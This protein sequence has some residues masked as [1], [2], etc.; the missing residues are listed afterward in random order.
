MKGGGGTSWAIALSFFD[1]SPLRPLRSRMPTTN[2]HSKT[3]YFLTTCLDALKYL[4]ITRLCFS[5]KGFVSMEDYSHYRQWLKFKTPCGP[6][7]PQRPHKL[8]ILGGRLR[9][10][11]LFKKLA[12]AARVTPLEGLHYLLVNSP[13]FRMCSTTGLSSFYMLYALGRLS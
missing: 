13:R 8:D 11:R 5:I 10:A 7:P 9:E 12:S 6:N 4:R 2:L 3:R 1:V